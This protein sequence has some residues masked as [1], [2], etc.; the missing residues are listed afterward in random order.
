MAL[1]RMSGIGKSFPGVRAL[2]NVDL[3]LHQGEILA[4]MGENGAGKSTLLKI[5]SGVQSPDSGTLEM[6]GKALTLPSPTAAMHSGIAVVHQELSLIPDLTVQ[7][8][9]FL[10][11]ETTRWL[12]PKTEK[13]EARKLLKRI[14][15]D[16]PLGASC[17]SLPIASQQLVELAR[18]LATEAKILILDEPTAALSPSEVDALFSVIRDLRDQGLGILYVSHRLEEIEAIAD[19]VLILRDG[20]RVAEGATKR[21]ERREIIEHMVGRSL[22]RE[23]PAPRATLGTVQLRVR[24]LALPPGVGPLSFDLHEGE[25]LGLAG[26]VGSGRTETARLLFGA[27]RATQG[28]IELHGAMIQIRSPAE[29]IAHGICLLSEDRKHQGLVLPHSVQENFGL[30]NLQSFTRKGLLSTVEER[31]AYV[32]HEQRLHIKTPSPQQPVGLLSGGNQQKVIIAKWLERQGSIFLF[33]E[34]TR[35]IDV[36]AKYEIYELMRDLTAAGKSILLISSE[37]PEVFGLADRILVLRK[38]KIVREITDPASASASE[39]LT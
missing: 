7:E 20:K 6:E 8:N 16:L 37:L 3:E 24:D 14:D 11:R 38:G 27:D 4:L 31:N 22:E 9:L 21:L 34:P 12:H 28:T 30:P 23:F 1:L 2:D 5:L 13:E 19:R 10:G 33:D 25:I 15:M 39:V 36:G 17:R 35:G 18:A 26:L 32:S 29:A